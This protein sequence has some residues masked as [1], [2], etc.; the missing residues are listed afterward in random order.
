MKAA[1]R[2]RR[3]SIDPIARFQRWFNEARRARIPLHNAMAL[4]TAD[5]R[6]RPSVRFVLLKHCNHRGFVF[7]TSVTSKKGR[8]L[9]ENPYASLVF[10]WHPTGKQVRID[11]RVEK[12]SAEEADMYWATRPRQSR[13]AALASKQSATLGSR[14]DLLA[15]MK[16]L[17]QKFKGKEIPRPPGWT[18][19]R[20][21][22]DA[23]E[24]WMHR[25]HRLHQ[26]EL[27]VR[28]QRGWKRRLL[29]P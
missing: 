22:P 24:F 13:L 10:Y 6:G 3:L 11:G 29:Q 9:R 27:F 19:F 7:Y 26:R 5:R 25:E 4:A 2:R 18:G 12:V 14:R 28:M 15:A 8:E 1:A 21:F 23:I 17:R 16:R 20:L